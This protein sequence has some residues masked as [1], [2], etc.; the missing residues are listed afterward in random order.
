MLKGIQRKG[1]SVKQEAVRPAA[2]SNRRAAGASTGL[3][4]AARPHH[5]PP[6]A[7]PIGCATAAAAAAAPEVL[8]EPP[9]PA[10]LPQTVAAAPVPHAARPLAAVR[11]SFSAAVY[12]MEPP[13]TEAT[14]QGPAA[15]CSGTPR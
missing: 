7:P 4:Y 12:L 13:T 2:P 9:T 1:F 10:V 15:V 8:L 5:L 3:R 6:R 14:M 11:C